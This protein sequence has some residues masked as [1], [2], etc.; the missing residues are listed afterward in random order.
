MAKVSENN[1]TS[2]AS[3][4]AIGAVVGVFGYLVYG[5]S[6]GE[7]LRE[8][9]QKE[10]DKIRELLYEEGIIDSQSASLTEIISAVQNQ[11][12]GLLDGMPK[13]KRTYAKK[14]NRK[15]KGI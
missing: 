4:F 8:N 1:S 3:G 9:F 5:T 12:Q 13:K 2:F 11:A 15:F 14:S 10:F 7:D 6:R